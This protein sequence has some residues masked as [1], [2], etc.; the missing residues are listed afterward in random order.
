MR[1]QKTCMPKCLE[2]ATMVLMKGGALPFNTLAETVAKNAIMYADA[3]IDEL[4]RTQ[5]QK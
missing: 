4:K 2:N 3:L 1:L 5:T